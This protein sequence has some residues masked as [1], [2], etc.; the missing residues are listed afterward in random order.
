MKASAGTWIRDGLRHTSAD[1]PL[2]FG[3]LAVSDLWLS[4]A[5]FGRLPALGLLAAFLLVNTISGQRVL[6]M[7][8][9]RPFPLAVL[10]LVI[11][12]CVHALLG[13]GAHG[14]VSEVGARLLMAL[15]YA[16]VAYS[17]AWRSDPRFVFLALVGANALRAVVAI[18]T[19]AFGARQNVAL[20]ELMVTATDS[21]L[22]EQADYLLGVGSYTLYA[23]MAL[24]VPL[25]LGLGVRWCGRW[26]WIAWGGATAFALNVVLCGYLLPPVV[27]VVAAVVLCAVHARGSLVVAGAVVAIGVMFFA[28]ELPLVAGV[29]EKAE[30]VL[31]TIS[32]YGILADPTGRGFLATVS[33]REA[34]QHWLIGVGPQE[35]V[36]ATTMRIGGHSTLFDWPAQYGLAG[37]LFILLSWG[38]LAREVID[39]DGTVARAFGR[40]AWAAFAIALLA[41]MVLN[42]VLLRENLDLLT[43][44]CLGIATA[45]ADR[46]GE[47]LGT[48]SG[49]VQG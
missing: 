38:A 4:K 13:R 44:G 35:F 36:H 6:W 16:T 43:F 39:E 22:T 1:L 49:V 8:L 34:A 25:L 27:L 9:M 10:V 30:S 33:L 18:P 47:R 12:L 26:R 14:A 19:L 37:V 5:M 45:S 31:E 11:D 41:A 46:A 17:L 28:R 40:S 23:T 21:G 7:R 20:S 3:F 32:R 48:E 29:F 2:G 24:A 42:P 15:S